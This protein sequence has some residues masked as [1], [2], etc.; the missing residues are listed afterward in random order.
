MRFVGLNP[1]CAGD[2]AV[3]LLAWGNAAN[4]W[5]WLAFGLLAGILVAID[6][7]ALRQRPCEP[8]LARS[9]VN[10]AVWCLLALAFNGLVAWWMN[11]RAALEFATGYLLE[12]SMSMDNVFVFAVIFRYFQV[13][14]AHQHRILRW[15]VFGAVVMRL[16]LIL[17]GAALVARFQF[18]LPLFGLFLLYSGAQLARRCP[19]RSDPQDNFVLRFARRW[20][21]LAG[22]PKSGT[23][24]DYGG[25]FLVRKSGRLRIAPPLLVLLVVEGADVLF[26][27]DSI[28]AIFGVTRDPFI[29]FSSNVFAI[30]GLRAVYFLLAGAMDM[31]RYLHYGLAAVLAF[32]GLKMIIEGWLLRQPGGET[33]P[34]WVSLAVIAGLL[35]AAVA[36]S[37]L[38]N[39]KGSRP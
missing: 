19:E 27:L 11:G 36:A 1:I 16:T 30:L 14:K 9:F 2:G 22:E 25:P 17:A 31:F 21:P 13:P 8:S 20:L 38:A 15:G 6:L 24:V 5:C 37:M 28:P 23:A 34:G 29:I 33:M 32:V 26:A 35:A 3:S 18:V 7:F 39:R 10:V 4:V 12:W